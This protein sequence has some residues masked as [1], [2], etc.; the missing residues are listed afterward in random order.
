MCV[1]INSRTCANSNGS[2]GHCGCI[3]QTALRGNSFEIKR[4]DLDQLAHGH[5]GPGRDGHW[6]RRGL[7]ASHRSIL[8]QHASKHFVRQRV[9]LSQGTH[10][11]EEDDGRAGLVTI[12]CDG[13]CKF[14]SRAS[15]P[16]LGGG[17][18]PA[19]AGDHLARYLVGQIVRC[20]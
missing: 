2:Q 1:H 5:V 9:S 14:N 7:L 8:S 12:V 18:Q 13:N 15:R 3:H 4:R 19:T 17:R 10:L 20:F 11:V 6:N 16:V